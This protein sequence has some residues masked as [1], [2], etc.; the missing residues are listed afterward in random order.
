MT[1]SGPEV[2]PLR[3]LPPFSSVRTSSQS[4]NTAIYTLSLYQILVTVESH[5]M[6]EMD[7][8]RTVENKQRDASF[9]CKEADSE[10]QFRHGNPRLDCTNGWRMEKPPLSEMV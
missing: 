7:V 2:S 4:N 5:E 8:S 3:S 6:V 10:V 9:D 1:A